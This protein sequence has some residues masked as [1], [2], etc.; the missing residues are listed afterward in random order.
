MQGE[1]PWGTER[2]NR[3]P[4]G[5][6]SVSTLREAGFA[7]KDFYCDETDSGSS[8]Q[9]VRDRGCRETTGTRIKDFPN[10][11]FSDNAPNG[12]GFT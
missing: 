2:A 3:G 8:R 11:H 6:D 7:E 5:I 10:P 12:L 1:K 4:R 9:G